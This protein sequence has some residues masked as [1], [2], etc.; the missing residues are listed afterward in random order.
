MISYVTTTKMLMIIW[1][2]I[3]IRGDNRFHWVSRV[4][5]DASWQRLHLITKMKDERD[6]NGMVDRIITADGM[7][8]IMMAY[9][10]GSTSTWICSA[11]T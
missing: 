11:W 10:N 9:G 1:R 2:S 6:V 4:C 8:M 5:L 3:S 7:A